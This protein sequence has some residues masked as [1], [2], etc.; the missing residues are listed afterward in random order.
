MTVTVNKRLHFYS[1]EFIFSILLKTEFGN[2]TS[3]YSRVNILLA[4]SVDTGVIFDTFDSLLDY[5]P[6]CLVVNGRLY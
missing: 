3:N 5:L 1:K 2:D 4:D 6:A